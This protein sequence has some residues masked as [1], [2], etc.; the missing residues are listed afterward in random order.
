ME[1]RPA[2]LEDIDDV[3]RILSDIRMQDLSADDIREVF[4]QTVASP[5]ADVLLITKDGS[6]L[7]MG[8]VNCVMKL[9]RIECRLDEV[10][11]LPEARGSGVGS[12]L[13]E[14]CN[15]WAWD[16]GCY[17]IE[18]TSRAERGSARAFYDKMGYEK[19]D[20]AIY[21]KFSPVGDYVKTTVI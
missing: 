1:V 10:V 20:S 11:V 13:V 18:F 12:M 3:A 7:G 14:A 21:T 6:A 2:T 15:Q 5:H 19:R 16:H 17:K 4:F 8:V 9:N